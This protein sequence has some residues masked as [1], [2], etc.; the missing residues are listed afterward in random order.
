MGYWVACG[1]RIVN[2]MRFGFLIS[3]LIAS[4]YA[5]TALF[6]SLTEFGISL[7]L[8]ALAMIGYGL[9]DYLDRRHNHRITRTREA[10]WVRRDRDSGL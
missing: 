7:A 8:A 5:F 3:A 1:G 2:A 6:V 4:M 9:C 10:V